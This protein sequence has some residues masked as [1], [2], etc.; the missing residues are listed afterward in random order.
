MVQIMNEDKQNNMIAG[1]IS[2]PNPDNMPVINV[3]WTGGWDSSFRI[4]EL[5]RMP[6]KIQPIYMHGDDRHSEQFERKAMETIT[7]ML[8]ERPETKAEFLPLRNV[9]INKIEIN[10]AVSDAYN[11]I[12]EKTGLGTQMEYLSSYVHDHPGIE[13][14]IEKLPV[15]ES[16]MI[17][18]L[19]E[20]CKIE[21]GLVNGVEEY[22]ANPDESSEDG[23]L[24]FGGI[25]LP[26]FDRTEADML[27]LI[28]EWGYLDIMKQV[29]FCHQP[30]QGRPCGMCHPCEVK[31]GAGMEFLL[32]EDAQKRY[33]LQH[34]YHDKFWF[35]VYRKFLY[36]FFWKH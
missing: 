30:Y 24:I 18:A 23:L 5:S 35:K 3:F 6:V 22:Y 32:P 29:W 26:I 11:R 12:R 28:N 2:E 20:S 31:M 16:H 13:L 33:H 4:C 27:K 25:L 9:D 21:H 17:H 7:R 15:E 14:G 19:L 8:Q 36:W 10:P 1:A 34:R